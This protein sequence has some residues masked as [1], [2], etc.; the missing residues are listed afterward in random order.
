MKQE[1]FYPSPNGDEDNGKKYLGAAWALVICATLSTAVRVWWD[2]YNMI[3]GQF[4]N[5]VGLGLVTAEVFNG[6]GRHMY[7]LQP[8]QQRRFYLIGWLD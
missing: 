3:F 4:V 2:D 5:L 1:I 7:Y 6:L 8:D